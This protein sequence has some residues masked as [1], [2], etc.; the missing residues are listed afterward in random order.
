MF[1]AP[2][3]LLACSTRCVVVPDADSS[4]DSQRPGD[5]DDS[6]LPDD[7]ADSAEETGDTDTGDTTPTSPAPDYD[8]EGDWAVGILEDTTTNQGGRSMS[9]D[10]WYPSLDSDGA[11][12]LYGWDSWG[13]YGSAL[14]D[15]QPDCSEPRPVMV[16]SHG[17]GSIRW[18]MFWLPEFAATHGWL[19]VAADHP[20]NTFVDGSTD[21][22]T[23]LTQRPSDVRATYDWLLAQV[24]SAEHPLHGCVDPDAG[25]VVTGY[26]FGGYTAYVTGG[27]STTLGWEG[28]TDD[29]VTAVVTYAPWDAHALF[30]GTADIQVPVLS[31]GGDRDDTVGTD[32]RALH[33]SV[34]ST[35]R[36]MGAFS[37]AGHYSFTPIYCSG[38]GDGCGDE[39]ISVELFTATV[40]TSVLAFLGHLRGEEGAIE[41]LPEVAGELE[42]EIVLEEDAP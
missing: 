39:F 4:R 21:Y 6:A 2:L 24:E 19:V 16:H 10:A 42:W 26:S 31:L 40:R 14:E 11:A 35:P 12:H 7:T 27:A 3:L 17:N 5:T 37:N 23:L 41:Q 22:A 13:F 1:Y 29:R 18:E 30:D 8:S 25:Y 32:Y 15:A 38:S 20:G 34:G 33:G 28:L 36:V 9:V